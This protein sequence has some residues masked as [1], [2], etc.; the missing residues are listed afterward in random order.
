MVT[1]QVVTESIAT[2]EKARELSEKEKALAEELN[3][4]ASQM[5]EVVNAA[6]SSD[7][8]RPVF[9]HGD[10][11]GANGKRPEPVPF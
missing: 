3:A 1:W 11:N 9:I 7:L 10:D 2:E 6:S 8:T 5:L 4:K